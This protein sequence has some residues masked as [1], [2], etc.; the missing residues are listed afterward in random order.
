M[1]DAYAGFLYVIDRGQGAISAYRVSTTTGS[2]TPLSPTP[3]ATSGP[4]G[5]PTS[6]AIRSDDTWM[7]VTNLNSASLSEYAITPA[8]GALTPQ[9]PV[10]TDNEPWGVAV[11]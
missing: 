2:L 6:M 9:A 7:F 1:M 5:Y 3:V 11:R 10:Q 4:S 8:T